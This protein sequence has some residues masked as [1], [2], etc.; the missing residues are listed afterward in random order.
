[1]GYDGDINRMVTF[2]FLLNLIMLC[3]RLEAETMK[4]RGR[5]SGFNH[6]LVGGLEHG[7]YFPQ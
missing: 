7:F 6:Q 5:L 2:F 4:N 3:S 1:M